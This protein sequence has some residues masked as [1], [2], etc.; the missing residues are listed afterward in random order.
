M[1][2][3]L[4][5]TTVHQQR[6]EAQALKEMIRSAQNTPKNSGRPAPQFNF[7]DAIQS[8]TSNGSI[9]YTSSLTKLPE[10]IENNGVY[11]PDDYDDRNTN[12]R[13]GGINII[14]SESLSRKIIKKPS[15]SDTKFT[16]DDSPTGSVATTATID[17]TSS[18][19]V[20]LKVSGKS[21]SVLI[22]EYFEQRIDATDHTPLVSAR[23]MTGEVP[24]RSPTR[25]PLKGAS[26]GKLV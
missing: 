21:E 15:T 24:T 10:I 2:Y 25:S 9:S 22:K 17:T 7:D 18:A 4:T 13:G 16:N 23:R 6:E 20:S 3:R 8:T 5:Q 12:N 1:N 11:E 19:S 26:S 14:S